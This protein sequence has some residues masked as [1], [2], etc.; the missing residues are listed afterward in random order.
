M[1][2]LPLES[3]QEVHWGGLV[4]WRP[5]V[6]E[7]LNYCGRKF[8]YN[9]LVLKFIYFRKSTLLYVLNDT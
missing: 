4:L 9:I 2:L 7:L 6:W 1:P 3:S 5:A 8:E